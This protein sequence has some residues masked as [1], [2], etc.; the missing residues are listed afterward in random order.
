MHTI[1][2]P[3][4]KSTVRRE[5]TRFYVTQGD[6]E[7]LIS[8]PSASLFIQCSPN[9]NGHPRGSY[10]I[11]NKKAREFI[12]SKQGGYN[13]NTHRNFKQDSI[14]VGL[15]NFF[16]RSA[17]PMHETEVLKEN[18]VEDFGKKTPAED[19]AKKKPAED[20]GKKKPET[21]TEYALIKM[22]RQQIKTNSELNVIK[23]WMNFL[24]VITILSVVLSLLALL[25]SL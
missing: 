21:L 2:N 15:E 18:T 7:E 25:S 16:S 4:M 13:W 1:E 20:F 6:Y 12:E 23:K 9:K 22:V 8:N 24:G 3:G 17:S 19:F 5:S 10:D 11:P 14:P